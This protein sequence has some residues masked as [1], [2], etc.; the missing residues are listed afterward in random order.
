MSRDLLILVDEAAEAVARS[1]LVGFFGARWGEWARGSSLIQGAV[2]SMTVVM[3]FGLVEYG[4]CVSLIDDQE[5]V[6][7]FAADRSD[8]ALGGRVRPWRLYRRLDDPDLDRG[9]D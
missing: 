7:E 1:D 5:V 4:G 9:E 8:E 6:E 3:A 2:W